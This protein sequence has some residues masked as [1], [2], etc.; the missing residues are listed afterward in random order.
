MAAKPSNVE[1]KNISF[2]LPEKLH[3]EFRILCFRNHTNIK[4]ALLD[5]IEE[6]VK[7]GVEPKRRR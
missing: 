3:A 7:E 2:K 4:R 5:Y 6:Q 1:E